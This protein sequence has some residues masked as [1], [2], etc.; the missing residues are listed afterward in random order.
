VPFNLGVRRFPR[1]ETEKAI[2]KLVFF[3]PAS[4]NER[5]RYYR[6]LQPR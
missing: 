2:I 4:T 3:D 5:Q 1:N 6:A